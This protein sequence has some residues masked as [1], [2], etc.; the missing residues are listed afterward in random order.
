MLFRSEMQSL[1]FILA[2]GGLQSVTLGGDLAVSAERFIHVM[3]NT[4]TITTLHIDGY[5]FPDDHALTSVHRLP[6]LEWDDVVAFR[7]P[8]LRQLTLSN[9]ALTIHP[10]TLER[11]GSLTRL[12]LN[13]VDIVDGFLPDLCPAAWD[14][15]RVLKVVG[16]S[17]PEMDDHVLPVLE[18]CHGLQEFYYAAEDTSIHPSIFDE[19]AP[20]CP[21]L[22]TLRLS[23]FD[24]NPQTLHAIAEA[25]PKLVDLA[26]LGRITRIPPGE[27]TAYV[28]SG[29]LPC[30]RR[31]VTPAGTNL[32]PFTFWS[33]DQY[34]ALQGACR[35]RGIDMAC[36]A[37]TTDPLR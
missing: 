11:P 24:V 35:S 32:P 4:C 15:L 6:S 33:H 26:V 13:N 14:T 30:L 37:V 27:W 28:Q 20:T 8:H 19:D 17:A 23:G 7:F 12:T 34:A 21:N 31:L 25:C 2:L 18:L 16:K 9:V 1:R 29:K 3:V 10:P 5:T 22:Q 36:R